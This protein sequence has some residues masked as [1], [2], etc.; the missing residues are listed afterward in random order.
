MPSICLEACLKLPIGS[1][2]MQTFLCHTLQGVGPFMREIT[3]RPTQQVPRWG[4]ICFVA[5]L[6]SCMPN[7]HEL[8]ISQLQG[9]CAGEL[10]EL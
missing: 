5:E 4:N 3:W 8:Q 1:D 2:R 10:F 7:I 6:V 9:G